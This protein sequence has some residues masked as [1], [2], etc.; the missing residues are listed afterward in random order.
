MLI[1]HL[2]TEKES[3]IGEL[4]ETL[5]QRSGGAL[6]V[7]F[8]YAAIYR[9]QQADYITETKKR[10]APDGRRR[11]Y[12]SVTE[13]GKAYLAQLLDGYRLISGGIAAILDEEVLYDE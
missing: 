10:Q 11:Q 6:N 1:L 7:V 3:Y 12:Y 9:L 4:T 5:R 13:S 2:L 8:P